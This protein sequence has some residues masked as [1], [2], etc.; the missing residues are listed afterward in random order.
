MSL[1]DC[2]KK[3]GKSINK[4]DADALLQKREELIAK[5]VP[6]ADSVAL[7]ILEDEATAGVDDILTKAGKAPQ[8]APLKPGVP[9]LIDDVVYDS[10]K[11]IADMD[12]EIDG[13]DS[14]MGCIY[15]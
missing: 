10:N 5:G 7:R 3:A 12:A 9:V 8:K 4:K 1:V 14:I 11:F 2:L 15:K 13:I 6:D